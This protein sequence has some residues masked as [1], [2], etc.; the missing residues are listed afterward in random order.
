MTE[1]GTSIMAVQRSR[2]STDGVHAPT[3]HTPEEAAQI[4]RVRKSWLERQAAARRIPFTMPGGSYRFTSDHLAEIVRMHKKVPD[5][6]P[7]QQNTTARHPRWTTARPEVIA[8][9]VTPLRPRPRVDQ[10][11]SA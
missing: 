3:P 5:A 4:L 2:S 9:G 8:N 11:R 6:N 7:P 1:G 10:R